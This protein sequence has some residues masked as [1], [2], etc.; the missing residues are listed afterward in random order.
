M[1]MTIF[2]RLVSRLFP[3]RKKTR[4]PDWAARGELTAKGTELS[5]WKKA[6]LAKGADFYGGYLKAFGLRDD[7]FLR[8]S[9]G[10]FGCGPFGGILSALKGLEAAY[11]IDVLADEYNSWGTSASRIFA[12]DGCLTPVSTEC[13]DVMFSANALDHTPDPTNSISEIF[14]ILKPGGRLYVHVHLRADSEI[15]KAHPVAWSR[16]SALRHFADFDVI[17]AE[18]FPNDW[19]NDVPMR[20]LL[21]AARK[22]A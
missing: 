15:N 20:M 12:F 21:L 9:V 7:E 6:G 1:S 13:C 8:L 5:Y 17:K 22:P 19:I 2:K 14:R 3:G 4:L 11:P 18:E 10:D 16:A